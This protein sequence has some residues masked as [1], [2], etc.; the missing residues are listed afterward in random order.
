MLFCN[1]FTHVLFAQQTK[2][3]KSTYHLFN[4]TPR[5]EMR[6]M[7]TDRPDITET[8]FTVDAGHYQF[9]FD[10]LSL[11]RHY[12]KRRRNETD[13]LLLNGIAKVGLTDFVDFELIFSAYQWHFP[14]SELKAQSASISRRR[15]FGDLG[16][17]AKFNLLGNQHESY[18]IAIM[19]SLALPLQNEASEELYVP[20]ITAIWAYDLNEKWELGGQFEYHRIF[21]LDRKPLY[22]EYWATLQVGYEINQNFGFF[23]EYVAILSEDSDYLHTFN[24]GLIFEV[25]RD[26]HLDLAFNL[27]LNQLS[28]SAVFSGFSFRF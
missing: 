7:H 9:E 12:L 11:N 14:D 2:A 10:F 27:G 20:G 26:F 15:G 6:A 28:P 24:A 25:N 5:N 17:R 23:A 21:D 19:P 8:P 16:F 3:E 4:P 22:N 13:L 18:G 1:A